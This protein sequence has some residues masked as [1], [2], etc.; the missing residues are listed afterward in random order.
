MSI[1]LSMFLEAF[2]LVFLIK[3]LR[4]KKKLK[5]K[6]KTVH[7]IKILYMCKSYKV[8]YGYI[9]HSSL[10]WHCVYSEPRLCIFLKDKLRRSQLQ[11]TW[12]MVW[13]Q[14]VDFSSSMDLRFGLFLSKEDLG[15]RLC[16]VLA[17]SHEFPIR[18]HK[19]LVWEG[20]KKGES[21]E[22]TQTRKEK[23]C[24]KQSGILNTHKDPR[25]VLSTTSKEKYCNWSFVFVHLLH[26]SARQSCW[27]SCCWD[28]RETW[29]SLFG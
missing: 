24:A 6:R 11:S 13:T 2:I 3:S 19:G 26:R 1:R 29:Y 7:R 5:K 17:S 10:Q 21:L 27:S 8:Q 20:R 9:F 16:A 18:R 12:I 28:Y 14:K 25:T 15:E 23:K 4:F 22:S